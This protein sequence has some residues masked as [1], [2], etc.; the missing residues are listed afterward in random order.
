MRHTQ[1]TYVVVEKRKTNKQNKTKQNR[2]V[3]KRKKDAGRHD[4]REA[5]EMASGAGPRIVFNQ[6]A[7]QH[8]HTH[9]HRHEFIHTDIST[10]DLYTDEA[11]QL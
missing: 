2:K 11:E 1:N 8:T 7:N 3:K 6:L 5:V 4:A 10:Q 9:T